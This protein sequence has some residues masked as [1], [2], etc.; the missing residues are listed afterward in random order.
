MSDNWKI[1]GEQRRELF[2]RYVDLQM[3]HVHQSVSKYVDEVR[4]DLCIRDITE[5]IPDI[6]YHAFND[7]PTDNNAV[8]EMREIWRRLKETEDGQSNGS[9]TSDRPQQ[10]SHFD[11]AQ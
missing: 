5:D 7:K 11:P 6:I 8:E 1:T 3:Q 10:E 9:T 4:D 2:R